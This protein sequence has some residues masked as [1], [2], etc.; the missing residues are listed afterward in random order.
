VSRRKKL[1]TDKFSSP[2]L[3]EEHRLQCRKKFRD[4]TEKLQEGLSRVV[5]EQVN[6]ITADL[7]MLR[8][9]NAVLESEK[10]PRFRMRVKKGVER[11]KREADRIARV[12]EAVS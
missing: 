3:F 5:E 1:I 7:D 4:M 12:V 9:E 2:S 6:Y 11:A 8:G 10:N